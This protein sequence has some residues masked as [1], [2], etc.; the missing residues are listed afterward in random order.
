MDP[1][2]DTILSE[3]HE[4]E[5]RVGGLALIDRFARQADVRFTCKDVWLTNVG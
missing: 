5:L 2:P 3:I 4:I 1:Q